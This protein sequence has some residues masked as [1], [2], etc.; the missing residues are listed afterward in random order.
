MRILQVIPFFTPQMGG[1]AQ[2]AYQMSRHLAARGHEITVVT[3]DFSLKESCFEDI[4]FQVIYLPAVLAGFGFYLTPQLVQ[5]SRENVASFDVIH[6]HTVR[7]YQNAVVGHFARKFGVP[8][9][10]S[11]H[12]TLPVIV[13]RKLPKR[14]YDL[15]FGKALL[16]G[17]SRLVAVSP[18]E[19]EQ[20]RQFG[21]E[22]ER[23]RIIYNG[24]D[25]AEFSSLPPRGRLRSKLGIAASA[26]VVLYLGRLHK[27]KGIDKLIE[28]FARLR[29]EDGA[30]RLLIAGPDEGEL[31]R[32]QSLAKRL[33][34]HEQV[35]FLGPLYG[36]EKLAA[37]VDADVLASPAVYEIFGLVP[38]EAL[39]CGTPVVVTNDCGSGQIIAEAKA[40]YLVPYAD[41]EALK[42]AIDCMLTNRE[43]ASR[44][45]RAGQE[46]I[47][48]RLTWNTVIDDL[49]GLFREIVC[50]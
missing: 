2:A 46:Y 4:S 33:G 34:V 32:L 7:T 1:S 5:W 42:A 38:F 44:Q 20:Y 50:E 13:Q 8:Y 12:G 37:Y 45:V 15:I 11:A 3:S 28:A 30:Y 9:L 35:R 43:K 21:I 47:R 31:S 14:I 25:L 6:M 22:E 41:I 39:L 24:L 10:V 29:A 19:V 36:M 27:R 48:G 18:V 26:K 23:I 40:G 49:E 16:R 17:A